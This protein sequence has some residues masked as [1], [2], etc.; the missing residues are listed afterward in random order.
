M[1]AIGKIELDN[2]RERGVDGQTGRGQ[3][4]AESPSA[5]VPYGY[6]IGDD[7]RPEI[8]EDEGRGRPAAS[9]AC[10]CGTTLERG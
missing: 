2:F 8:A 10:A 1:A 4:G 6:R 5:N 9:S 3:A 7:G